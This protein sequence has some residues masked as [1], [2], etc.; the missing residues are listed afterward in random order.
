MIGLG[1]IHELASIGFAGVPT[2]CR[3]FGMPAEIKFSLE[4]T[5]R[6]EAVLRCQEHIGEMDI[7]CVVIFCMNAGKLRSSSPSAP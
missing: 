3:K 5:D 6:D 4:T 7:S 2:K 1:K